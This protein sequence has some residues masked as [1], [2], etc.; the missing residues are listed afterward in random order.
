MVLPYIAEVI[1]NGEYKGP[2]QNF[3]QDPNDKR[4][5]VVYYTRKVVTVGHQKFDVELVM[6]VAQLNSKGIYRLY[7]I[8][9]A[10]ELNNKETT[11][12]K[13]KLQNDSPQRQK[14]FYELVGLRVMKRQ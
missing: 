4:N 12:K 8:S 11:N 5:D 2:I 7:C 14:V 13:R 1:R 9:K 3:H 6:K 10:D